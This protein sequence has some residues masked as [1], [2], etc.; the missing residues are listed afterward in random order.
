M[1]LEEKKASPWK[2]SVVQ[3][4]LGCFLVELVHVTRDAAFQ[5]CVCI[6]FVMLGKVSDLRFF[7]PWPLGKRWRWA[8]TGWPHQKAGRIRSCINASDSYG[9]PSL[10]NRRRKSQVPNLTSPWVL[11]STLD[12]NL[13]GCHV[14]LLGGH[15][16]HHSW[17][18]RPNLRSKVD[19]PPRLRAEAWDKK[20]WIP[21][22]AAHV[23]FI[24]PSL[25]SNK[26]NLQF[27]LEMVGSMEYDSMTKKKA[28]FRIEVLVRL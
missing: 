19:I 28:F 20:G 10:T 23:D 26:P 16:H 7:Y 3:A 6:L 9:R 27:L 17:R 18:Q 13:N 5:P 25:I 21:Q 14:F 22:N 1:K 11:S 4:P 2:S 24:V 15:I 8:W 12:L